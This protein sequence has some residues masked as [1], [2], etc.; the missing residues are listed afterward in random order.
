M[1]ETDKKLQ[2]I[3][4]I[5][6]PDKLTPKFCN[7]ISFALSTNGLVN[8][9]LAFNEKGNPPILIERVIIDINHAKDVSRVL[10]ELIEKG[11]KENVSTNKLQQ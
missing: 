9:T 6:E 8:I 4:V 1:I 3:N 5:A 2:P 7:S 11:G 10:N